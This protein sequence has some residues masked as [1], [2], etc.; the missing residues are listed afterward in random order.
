MKIETPAT[1]LEWLRPGGPWALSSAVPDGKFTT[2]R[3]TDPDEVAAWV[4]RRNGKENMWYAV[5]PLRPEYTADKKATKGI[6]NK[7]W[8]PLK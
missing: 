7:C 6:N 8:N 3:F 5:N 2:T 4:K 1:F